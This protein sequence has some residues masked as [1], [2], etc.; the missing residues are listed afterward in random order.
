MKKKIL[1]LT[2]NF[3][4]AIGSAGNRMKNIYQ[5]LNKAEI[6]THVLT[7]DPSYP[8]QK[9]YEDKKFWDEPELNIEKRK[10]KRVPIK[11]KKFSNK[12]LSR[13]FF[14]IEIMYR[15]IIHLFKQRKEGYDYIL[16]STPPIFIVL[17]AFIGVKLFKCKLILEVR[18]LWPDSLIGVRTFDNK[19]IIKLFRW[20]EKKMYN[21]ADVIVIN[22]DGFRDHITNKLTD[23]NKVLTYLP[24]GPRESEIIHTKKEN[25][26]FKVVY[27]GNL[28]LAQDIDR[29]KMIAHKLHD[30]NVKLN[31]I[32]YGMKVGEFTDF[33]TRNEL[34]N[35]T[36]HKPSTRKDSLKLIADSDISVAFLNDEE[37]FS[38]VLPGKIID[39]MTCRTPIIAGV[40]GTAAKLIEESKTGFAF[41]TDDVQLM[42]NK[43]VELK[44]NR[45]QLVELMDNCTNTVERDFLWEENVKNLINIIK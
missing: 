6:D 36:I 42:V 7:I 18:D 5:L 44:G 37:V 22:S 11:N 19:W 9:M 12:V 30:N 3:Y 28:G 21:K 14:Y 29:L 38:T 26:T 16:V 40:K 15:F 41:E 20:L 25:D 4:P 23:K 2:Q 35:V 43:V 39:Y 45:Q 27:A 34:Y 32:G 10:I 33:L 31:I 1:I 24:N 8:N 13:L 17:S